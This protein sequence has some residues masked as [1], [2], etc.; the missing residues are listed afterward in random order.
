MSDNP[1][2]DCGCGGN[3]CNDAVPRREFLKIAGLGAL[4]GSAGGMPVM[5]GPFSADG[6]NEYLQ[7][8]PIDKKLDPAWVRSLFERGN[9]EVYSDPKAL[10]HIG[11]PVGGIGAGLV[12]LGGDGRLWMWD[13]FN[14]R[15]P[16]GF[17]GRGAGGDTYLHPF[18]PIQP[19]AHGFQLRVQASAGGDEAQI[20]SLDADGFANVTFDGRYPIGIVTYEDPACA[21][22][23]QLEA[24][25]PFIPLDLENSS[26]PATIMRY[27]LS[28]VSDQAVQ[29][30]VVGWV[31]N[32][33]C[34]FTGQP[35]DT[36][37]RN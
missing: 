6:D 32:P 25:S 36:L 3:G 9:K 7:T 1:T 13:V 33:V 5:A 35:R 15:Y 23:V 14:K 16:R 24:F 12:Y 21:V 20:H 4:A 26:Y 31:D 22:A 19:F 29:A 2:D 17:M 8:I 28:N 11:M 10:R 34:L 18:E 30:S 37:R 27:T